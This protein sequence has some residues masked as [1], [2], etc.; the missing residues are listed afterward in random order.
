MKSL[1]VTDRKKARTA[2]YRAVY[3]EGSNTHNLPWA[4][5][6]TRPQD[7]SLEAALDVLRQNWRTAKFDDL[8]T[9]IVLHDINESCKAR[10]HSEAKL[11]NGEFLA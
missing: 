1:H 5:S 2:I 6:R 10:G 9:R 11:V 8:R 3:G 4:D 7:W